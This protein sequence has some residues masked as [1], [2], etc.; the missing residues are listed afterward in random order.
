[1]ILLMGAS[2]YIGNY[3]FNEFKKENIDILGTYLQNK[4]PEAIKFDLEKDSISGLNLENKI[5]YLIISAAANPKPDI[6][7]K[8][9]NNS[10]LINVTKTKELIDYCFKNNITPVYISTDNIFDGKKGN[11]KEGDER[12]PLNSYG[13]IKYEIENY[14]LSSEK[15]F[16]LLR[17]G[18]TFKTIKDDPTLF[19]NM[20]AGDKLNLATDQ[21][22]T[23]LYLKDLYEFMKK[24]I[25]ENYTGIFHL[26]SVHPTTRYHIAKTTRDFFNIKDVELIPCSIESLGLLEKRP[27]LI[28]LNVEKY[29]KL[30][31]KKQEEIEHFLRMIK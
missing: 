13:Q 17:M 14:L 26:A 12:N 19:T 18:K 25:Q 21:V 28:D 6:S 30:M 27:K 10:Y 9:W 22:F 31:G 3:L 23:P 7:K 2:G 24:A 8:Y 15:S 16:L 5:D 4:I 29:K 20:K 11:Y 1:M